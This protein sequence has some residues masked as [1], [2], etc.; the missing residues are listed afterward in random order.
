VRTQHGVTASAG[1][2][3]GDVEIRNYLRNQA[4]SRNLVF[5]LS[6]AHDRFGSS[7][8]VQ[9][10]GCLSHPQ[11]LD[12]QLRIAVQRKIAAYQQQY[13]DNQN[14]SFLPAIVST[15][16]R[17]HGEFLRLLFLQAHRETE[18][19]FTAVGMSSQNI[20]TETL[21]FKRDAFYNGLKS[22]VGRAVAK[23]AALRVNL[24]VQGCS[25]VAPPMH[26]PSRTPLLLPLRL[27]HNLPTPCVS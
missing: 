23:A 8:H 22:K 13:T 25:I 3:R 18:V 7:S 12:A 19:H 6:L 5:D 4:G 2:R 10:N 27:S 21:R 16:T 11:D 1:Q 14:I 17:M 15:S 24:N 20:N 9:Q 26:V